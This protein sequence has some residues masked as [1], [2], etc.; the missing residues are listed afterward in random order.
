MRKKPKPWM[1]LQPGVHFNRVASGVALQ[2]MQKV[3]EIE[4]PEVWTNDRYTVN[5][6]RQ[7]GNLGELI[8]M[9]IHDHDRSSRHDWRDLQRIKND[10]MGPE[11]EAIEIYPAESRLVDTANEWH[12]WGIV[13]MAWPFGYQE[14]LVSEDGVSIGGKQ[15]SW[16]EGDKPADLVNITEEYMQ[17]Q[18]KRMEE[19]SA[20]SASS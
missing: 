18:L 20:E 15:R 14:R 19:A 10:I 12:L 5:V 9:S 4:K 13:G 16:P 6:R 3:M 7:Q 8:H 1:P 2:L 11:G 17:E